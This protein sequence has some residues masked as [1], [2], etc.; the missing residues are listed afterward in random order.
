MSF[1]HTALAQNY[2]GA[3]RGRVTDPRGA[4]IA[5]AQLK[6]IEEGTNETRTLKTDGGGDFTIS[7]LRPGSYRLEV[8]KEGFYKSFE[9][10]VVRVNQE[11]RLDVTLEV[12]PGDLVPITIADAAL[13]YEGA[14]QGAVIDNRQVAGLP[15][16]GRNFLELSLL[17][18]GAAPAAQGS[19][20]S[21]RGD[22]T[23]NINGSREDANNFLLDG[24]YNVDPKLNTFG[25]KPPVDAIREFEVLA[26]AY[27]AS[28]GR[29]AGAQ[30][31]IVLKS[32]TNGVHGTAYE[33]LRNQVL[34]A[35]NFFAPPDQP[36]P[37]NQRNQ[38]GF[39]L[40]GPIVKD[41]TFFFGDY[42]GAR[43]REGITRLANVPSARER[44]GDFSQLPVQQ[45]PL[46]PGTQTLFPA[47]QIPQTFLNPIGLK[48]A[49]L[50]PLPNRNVAGLNFASS[51]IQRDRNDLFDLRFD[52]TYSSATQF[53][54]RYSFTDRTLFEPFSGV[55]QVFV[56][57]YGNNLLRR[58]QNLML[59]GTHVFSP[60]L[61]NDAR[62]A[63]NRV[64][65]Q[66]LIENPGV[67]VNRQVGLPE[68]S[69]NSRDFGLSFIRVTGFS[70]LGHEFNN[71][72]RGATNNFQALDTAT[73]ARGSHLLKFGFNFQYAQQNA[74]RNVQSRGL[75]TFPSQVSFTLPNCNPTP[76]TPSCS[77]A[78]PFI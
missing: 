70:P 64:S 3:I 51:P 61:I 66:V 41:R 73:Y 39:S 52:H 5:G 71:P 36:D 25:V 78:I 63:Y 44:V 35:R 11:T 38:F 33:F 46:I 6:L 27:D 37:R 10:L 57:G 30:V 23:F 26:S 31:N 1:A 2:R 7:L 13:K 58:G 72:Q 4:S 68:L 49:A 77:M 19:A 74:F 24:V 50:Y 21:V 22:F 53:S 62:V 75:L 28:F 69:N 42:E 29:S 15:L 32:G 34:D 76:A 16:D 14:S 60:R 47:G 56:P 40:G 9:I 12:S 65:N 59:G 67:S 48:I 45:Q 17:T 43:F 20:G 55:T 8:E 18:P 54:A